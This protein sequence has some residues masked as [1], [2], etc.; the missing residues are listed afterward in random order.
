MFLNLTKGLLLALTL[1][2]GPMH[3]PSAW[4][5]LNPTP[6]IPC[7]SPH[8]ISSP[9]PGERQETPSVSLCQSLLC[10]PM[11]PSL[12]FCYTTCPVTL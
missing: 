7:F 3:V 12:C 9:T 6:G 5:P 10:L 4:T 8:D 2:W 11:E 1:P